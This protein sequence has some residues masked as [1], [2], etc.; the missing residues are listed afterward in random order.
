MADAASEVVMMKTYGQDSTG[1]PLAVGNH[2]RFR[3][4][5]YVVLGFPDTVSSRGFPS[6]ALEGVDPNT[7]DLDEVAVDYIPQRDLF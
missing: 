5:G 7:P 1:Y 3:G 6:I 4:K 2:V